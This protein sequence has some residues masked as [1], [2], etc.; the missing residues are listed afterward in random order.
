MR[1]EWPM[2]GPAGE[3]AAAAGPHLYAEL[4]T[5]TASPVLS[6]VRERLLMLGAIVT[7]RGIT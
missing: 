1:E 3:R 4:L 2:D 5:L 6:Q 7:W